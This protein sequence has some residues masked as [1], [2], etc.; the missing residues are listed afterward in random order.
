MD[1][2]KKDLLIKLLSSLFILLSFCLAIALLINL[3]F[4][5]DCATVI[6]G[7]LGVCATL[8]APV[9]A[10]FLYDSWKD[11]HNKNIDSKYYSQALDSFKNISTTVRKL[12]TLYEK[13]NYINSN[14]RTS[15]I[16][17]FKEKYIVIK[18]ELLQ[19]LAIFQSELI[20]LQNLSQD[21]SEIAILERIFQNYIKVAKEE[22]NNKDISL[23]YYNNMTDHEG[24][25]KDLK[26]ISNIQGSLIK[27]N[28]KFIVESLNSKIKA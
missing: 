18:N 4:R 14:N 12:K 20:F 2:K 9:A 22:L 16:K 15:N 6:V 1:K 25:E 23:N 10:F 24:L 13:C 26:N 8:Y 17:Y 28:I 27:S 3:K 11:Q 21:D 5:Q 7:M 19:N